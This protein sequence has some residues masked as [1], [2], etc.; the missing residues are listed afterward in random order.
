[1]GRV[2]SMIDQ[3]EAEGF[4]PC[5]NYGECEATCPK[6]ISIKFIGR[7]NRDY[8]RASLIEPHDRRGEMKP[9]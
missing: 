8:L 9:Q 4:G 6:D 2:V 7:M 5:R 3:M 1:M